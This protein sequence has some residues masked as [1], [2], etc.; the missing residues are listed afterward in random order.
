MVRFF[1]CDEQEAIL[2]DNING[3][4]LSETPLRT[5]IFLIILKNFAILCV[6]INPTKKLP[7]IPKALY[8]IKS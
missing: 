5:K 7:G 6:K 1:H 8:Y 2:N 4:L 3:Q